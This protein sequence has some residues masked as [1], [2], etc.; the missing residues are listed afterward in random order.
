MLSLLTFLVVLVLSIL[1]TRIATLALVHTGLSSESARFQARSAFTGVG[2]TT[3]EA[4]KVVRHPVR[5]RIVMLLML[6]GN[7]GMVT[8]V[9]SLLLTF[10]E[11]GKGDVSSIWRLLILAAGIALLWLAARS[12]LIDRMLSR[13]INR[14]L[15]RWTDLD[16]RDYASLLHLSGEYQVQELDVEE[17]DWLAGRTLQELGLNREGVLV[18]GIQRADDR[19]VGAPTRDTRIQAEDVLILYGRNSTLKDLDRRRSGPG[20][21]SEHQASVARQDARLREQEQEERAAENRR[22]QTR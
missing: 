19:F 6:L 5:R 7:A 10:L 18:L 3:A 14:A 8:A 2:F 11:I 17:E 22:Q 21:E 20:G 15:N 4:E 12:S 13:L 9:S 16:T 1:V